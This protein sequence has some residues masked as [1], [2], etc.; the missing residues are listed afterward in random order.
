[1]YDLRVGRFMEKGTVPRSVLVSMRVKYDYVEAKGALCA[2]EAACRAEI[3]EF[4][5]TLFASDYND[6]NDASVEWMWR[7]MGGLLQRPRRRRAPCIFLGTDKG[8]NGKSV[9]TNLLHATLGG[10]S[11]AMM[12]ERKYDEVRI[13]WGGTPHEH[14]AAAGQG[15]E[16]AARFAARLRERHGPGD[17]PREP[18]RNGRSAWRCGD[19]AVWLC[20]R[21]GSRGGGHGAQT[22]STRPVSE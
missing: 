19:C 4:Y 18:V 8:D 3:R 15:R 10:Y 21:G 9:F 17:L 11:I 2:E 1:M 16:S 12:Y 20:V 13:A 6:A 5:R 22:L 7:F 14:D